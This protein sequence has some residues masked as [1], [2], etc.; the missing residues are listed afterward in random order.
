MLRRQRCL[1]FCGHFPFLLVY[2]LSLVWDKKWEIC[3]IVH[4]RQFSP[5]SFIFYMERV[6]KA[7]DGG[8]EAVETA[9]VYSPMLSSK[10]QV[11]VPA[12]VREV[13]GAGRMI[14]QCLFMKKIAK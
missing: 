3:N 8:G 9:Y 10:K 13:F 4:Q 2:H 12:G 7:K 1:L 11:A 5:L 6:K 14:K